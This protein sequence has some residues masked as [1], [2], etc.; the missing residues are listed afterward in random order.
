MPA[1]NDSQQPAATPESQTP[2]AGG[3]PSQPV[4]EPGPVPY[5]RFAEVNTRMQELQRQLGALQDAEQQR[6]QD[7]LKEQGKYKELLDAREQE[8][9]VIKAEALRA[10]VA[11]AT[12]LPAELIERLKGAS[13]A[14]LLEDAKRLSA[15]L[16]PA[17]P[18]SPGVPPP[19]GAGAPRRDVGAMTPAQIREAW[20]KGEITF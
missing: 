19:G 6:Q 1:E 4:A 14:D 11:A 12:Q 16:K 13:E 3:Q 15:L 9:A 5:A 7:S 20:Q 18:S 10:R 2:A 8:L 17:A